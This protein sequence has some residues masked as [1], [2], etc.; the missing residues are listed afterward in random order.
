[1]IQFLGLLN[2]NFG[3]DAFEIL[4]MAINTFEGVNAAWANLW[5]NLVFNTSSSWWVGILLIASNIAIF[6]ILYVAISLFTAKPDERVELVVKT[7]NLSLIAAICLAGNGYFIS[8]C[9]NVAKGFEA[10]AVKTLAETQII[11]LSI[12]QALQNVVL[13][14]VGQERIQTYL[15]ECRSR[16]GDELVTCMQDIQP[17]I[18]AIVADAEANL[19]ANSWLAKTGRDIADF[20][21][22]V[23]QEASVDPRGALV[24]GVNALGGNQVVMAILKLFLAAVQTAFAMALE[25]ASILHSMLLPI[26]VAILFTPF[27]VQ[28]LKQWLQQF[29]F[30]CCNQACLY[31]GFGIGCLCSYLRSCRIYR[32]TTLLDFYKCFWPFFSFYNR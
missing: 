4:N 7:I 9:L 10:F 29:F 15:D 21:G 24:L 11:D 1:M 26:V 5:D 2:L 28:F 12:N 20:V 14:N 16:V 22:E 23:A 30:D 31:L 17:K 19:P 8:N 18:E 13:T 27:G 25:A 32:F 6:G 3:D